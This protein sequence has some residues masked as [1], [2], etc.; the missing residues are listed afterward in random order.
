MRLADVSTIEA[1]NAF[2]IDYLP[3]HNKQFAVQPSSNIDKHKPLQLS[4]ED[5]DKALAFKHQRKVRKDYSISFEGDKFDLYT[6]NPMPYLKGESIDVLE[7]LNKSIIIQF[8]G[9][10]IQ[11][12]RRENKKPVLSSANAKT[13]NY[14]VD[15][16]L[17]QQ[18]EQNYTQATSIPAHVTCGIQQS[19]NFLEYPVI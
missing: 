14:V 19:F 5:L 18:S 16:V 17:M 8:K 15:T 13:I 12:N 10:D 2:L 9:K 3:K 1:A 6:H 7:L 11:V 4:S